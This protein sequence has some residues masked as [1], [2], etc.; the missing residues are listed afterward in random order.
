MNDMAEGSTSV[1]RRVNE[2]AYTVLEIQNTEVMS[3]LYKALLPE[4]VREGKE[5][6]HLAFRGLS[7]KERETV[8]LAADRLTTVI[9]NTPNIAVAKG[10]QEFSV[11]RWEVNGDNMEEEFH[12]VERSTFSDGINWGRVI[13][14]LAFSVS[15]AAYVSSRGI[16][17]GAG[18]VLGWTSQVL[19]TTLLEFMQRENG[20]TGFIAYSDTLLRA[21]DRQQR[22]R[23]GQSDHAARETQGLWDSVATYGAGLGALGVGALLAIGVRQAFS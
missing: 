10:V 23:N 6:E 16:S 15:F 8:E 14:F 11:G 21:Q 18:S 3:G 22:R 5:L 13:A 12:E 19:N 9:N 1:T 4:G 7:E 2:T 17:G 20:W